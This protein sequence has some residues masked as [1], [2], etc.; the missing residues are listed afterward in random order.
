MGIVAFLIGITLQVSEAPRERILSACDK[1]AGVLAEVASNAAVEV[2]YSVAGTLT[3]YSVSVTVEGKQVRGFVLDRG[4]AAVQLFEKARVEN[5]RETFRVA[6]LPSS[7]S[8]APA[9]APNPV[10][11]APK[12]PKLLRKLEL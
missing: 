6:P 12:G 1:S 10:K 7:P 3:C 2:R 8:S 5:E 4:L 9:A 11:G